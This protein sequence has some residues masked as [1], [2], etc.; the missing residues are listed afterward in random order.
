[1]VIRYFELGDHFNRG[2]GSRSQQVASGESHQTVP[3]QC[4]PFGHSR[5]S[6]KFRQFGDTAASSSARRISRNPRQQPVAAACMRSLDHERCPRCNTCVTVREV[7]RPPLIFAP[8]R[9]GSHWPTIRDQV[10]A[11]ICRQSRPLCE[12]G[13]RNSR[14]L[15]VSDAGL[16]PEAQAKKN[17]RVS[18]ACASGFNTRCVR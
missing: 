9:S 18:F 17:E 15:S 14:S 8:K 6:T 2:N 5:K 3:M 11:N 12:R 1:M 10:T 16:K 4:T 13:S 7:Y